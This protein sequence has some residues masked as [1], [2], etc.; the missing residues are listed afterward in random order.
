MRRVSSSVAPDGALGDG[1]SSDPSISADGNTVAF[2]SSASNLVAT[3][4][5]DPF[6]GDIFVRDLSTN[7][8]E[9]VTLSSAGAQANFFTD[10][11]SPLSSDGGIVAFSSRAINLVPSDANRSTGDVFVRIRG[12]V[13]PL[14]QITGTVRDDLGAPLP[15]IEVTLFSGAFSPLA[16]TSSHADGTYTLAGLEPN[17]YY[18][19]FLDP[20][21]SRA[22]QWWNQQPTNVTAVPVVVNGADVTDIDGVLASIPAPPSISG[23]V[24]GPEGQPLEG[25][26]VQA[27]GNSHTASTLSDAQGAYTL[28]DLGT[29]SYSVYFVDPAARYSPQ[30]WSDTPSYDDHEPIPIAEGDHVTDIDAHMVRTSISGVVTDVSGQ[31]VAGIQVDAYGQT[32]GSSAVTDENGEYTVT[33]LL[34]DDYSVSFSDPAHVYS[35]EFW[36][37]QPNYFAADR[38]HLAYGEQRAGVDAELS[39]GSISGTVTSDDDGEPLA[40]ITVSAVGTY[41][42]GFAST[43]TDGTYE[44][45]GLGADSYQVFFQDDGGGV[46]SPEVWDDQPNPET[47]D[48]VTLGLAGTAS[49]IDAELSITTISGVVRDRTG[50]PI[51]NV[52]V[53]A[54]GSIWSGTPTTTDGSGR[55][56]IQGL[57][58]DDV[59]LAFDDP[60]TAQVRYWPNTSDYAAAELIPV[61]RGGDLTGFDL[62]FGDDETAPTIDLA[63]PA[64]GAAFTVGQAVA[65]LYSCHEEPFGSGLGS[66]TGTDPSGSQID[67][68][69]PGDRVFTVS[70]VDM[71]GNGRTEQV[72]YHVAAG[73][74]TAAVTGGETLTTDPGGLGASALVPVQTEIAVPAGVV[75]NVSVTPQ[76][77]G[78]PPG[79]F[80]LFGTQQVISGPAA[81]GPTSPYVVTFTVDSSVLGGVAPGDVQVF[82][83]GTPS[84]DCTAGSSATPDPC[85][86]ARGPS[87]IDP[88]DAA[89]TVRTTQFST[90]AIGAKAFSVSSANPAS[91]VQGAAHRLI[92]I[93]GTG[94]T[95]TS[96]VTFTTAGSLTPNGVTVNSTTLVDGGHLLADVSITN[97]A[98]PG[99]RDVKVAKAGTGNPKATCTSCFTVT[100]RPAVTSLS[101]A[102]RPQGASHQLVTVV[103]TGFQPGAVVTVDGGGVTSPVTSVTPTSITL[104]LSISD[105]AATGNRDV[106]VTNPDG[107]TFKKSNG[108]K[109]NAKPTVTSTNPAAVLQG[110]SRS[111]QVLGS[112]FG[113]GATVTFGPDITVG[114]ITRNSASK[115]T[116]NIVVSDS[117]APSADVVVTNPDGGT[118]TCSGCLA[119]HARPSVSLVSP[120]AVGQGSSQRVTIAGAGFASDVKITGLGGGVTFTVAE[121]T[122]SSIALDV[123]VGGNA[124]IG[125][126][127]ITVTNV[128]D[129][130]TTTCTSCLT[131]NVK[132]TIT[133]VNPSSRASGSVP[134]TVTITGAGFQSGMTVAVSES[135]VVL[136]NVAVTPTA[137]TA[138]LTVAGNATKGNH[139]IT[140]TNPDG[141]TSTKA[142]GLKVT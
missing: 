46:Y 114:A 22:P 95:P 60:G 9:L 82:R 76:P 19:R 24:T 90:W 36:D 111:V 51:Q 67:T 128:A 38:F 41:Y 13:T 69:T 31:G 83:N 101:P 77:V 74:V 116:A 98:A 50:A 142:N 140:V 23:F 91:G 81:T 122:E 127:S 137:V 89:I 42:S 113:A 47:S 35:T 100:V 87:P 56:T 63:S 104:D 84:P 44:I 106:T 80:V 124:T 45:R 62:I 66:C 52:Q 6:F 125:P 4:T 78:A 29:D 107:G 7:E 1:Y 40:G 2:R 110:A 48:R 11:T 32:F 12:A 79:G 115:L 53:Y 99:P 123:T 108:L 25:I 72:T 132:P 118:S 135:G 70:A 133:T 136:S 68:L 34:P 97:G 28:S 59:I 121:H 21:G 10:G 30:Y 5:N 85:V 126:R 26:S 75:G 134:V 92:T 112:G 71:A 102:D 49:A 86:A 117:A 93:S 109:V 8:T 3:D 39:V 131:V 14:G 138:T 103:G 129:G 27:W 64:D 130:G 120:T 88:S 18:V 37:N 61:V 94:F 119:V 43:G 141:G 65:T 16:S 20:T 105:T 17:S 139:S 57:G 54:Q 33:G 73:D 55:Y 96:T 15:S 58:E